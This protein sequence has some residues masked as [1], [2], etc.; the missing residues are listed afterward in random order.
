MKTGPD[1]LGTVDNKS[2]R[3]KLETGP[4]T[5]G[6]AENKSGRAKQETG[7]DTTDTAANVSGSGKHENVKGRPWYRRK[8]ENGTRRPRYS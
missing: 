1:T 8:K 3:A 4:D 5:L 2:G 6:T 7:P